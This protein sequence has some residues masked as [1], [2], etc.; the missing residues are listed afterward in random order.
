MPYLCPIYIYQMSTCVYRA[1]GGNREAVSMK[2][3]VSISL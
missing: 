2:V 1:V 3:P